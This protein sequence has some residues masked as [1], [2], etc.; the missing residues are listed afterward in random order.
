MGMF[1]KT[2][3][4][5]LRAVFFIAQRTAGGG[6]VGIKDVAG[7]ID[8][9][10]H[11]LA[12]VLKN[13]GKEGVIQSAK[14]PNGGF[15]ID[16]RDLKRPLADVVKAVDG[17]SIFNGCG[18]GLEQCSSERPCPLHDEFMVVRNQLEKM[19][20]NVTIGQFSEDLN[21]GIAFLKR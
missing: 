21:L 8:A 10:E 2:C 19:L 6:R 3:E 13:L 14:G 16:S 15:Y 5:A 18:L 11:F 1:S 7:H 4:Y 20:H 17:S 9:P 12:K